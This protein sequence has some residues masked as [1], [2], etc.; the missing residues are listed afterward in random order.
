M[1]A[2]N[3]K[4]L[5]DTWRLRGQMLSIALV[6]AGGV[7]SV[8]TM[9]S[10]YR[11]LERSRDAYYRDQRFADVFASLNR[12]PES[13][14]G[15][16]AAVPGVAAVGTR[17][18]FDATLRV[19]GLERS[20]T[21]RLVSI[22]DVPE[23]TLNDIFIR[24]GRYVAPRRD[25]EVLVSERFAGINGIAVGDTIGALINGRHRTLHVVGLALSPEFVYET[26]P[27]G[28]F[29]GDERLF[30]VLWMG[31]HA[32]AAA[33]DMTGA[34][35]DVVVRLGPGGS[36]RAVIAA[37][38]D[39]LEPFGGRGAFG[40]DDQLSNRLLEDELAQIRST[41]TV[42]P[43][44]FLG[45]AAF[46]LH[47]VML[48]L[49]A[50]ERE[51]I[52]TLK[53]FGYDDSTVALHYL[54]YA[55]LA[56]GVGVVIGLLGGIRLG[57]GYTALYSQYFR[58]PALEHRVSWPLALGAILISTAAAV[59]GALS[60]VRGA[61]RLQPAEAMRAEPPARFKPLFLERLG[62]HRR[63]G[64]SHRMILRNLERRP[65]RAFFAATG[66]A[67]A[68]A[69]LLIGF[70]MLDSV[71]AMM[72]LQFHVIQREDAAVS[73][74]VPVDRRALNELARVPG[75]LVVEPFRAVPVRLSN[76]HRDRRLALTGL[77]S[78]GTLRAMVG[79]SGGVHPLPEHGL[80]LSSRLASVLDVRAGDTV[81]AELLDRG[82]EERTLVVSATVDELLGLNGYLALPELNRTLREG[83][84]VS[85]AYLRIA[86]GEEPAVFERL[87][88]MPRIASAI[89]KTAMVRSFD[90][91]IA[92]SIGITTTILL[93]L[94]S[95]L[96]IG[97]IYNGAR[98]A[99]S[100]RGRELA[101]LR[102]LGFTRAEVAMMLLGEQAVIT[103][104]ALPIGTLIG[105]G[106]TTLI[107][108]AFESD[109]YRLPVAFSLGTVLYSAAVIVG[110]AAVAGLLVRRRLDRAN[111]IEV[112]KT[113]E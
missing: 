39:V 70:I 90:E 7:L 38:D 97:V 5:R 42:I 10:T 84:H 33:S 2:L 37:I 23:P 66:V 106:V 25:D 57:E 14:A 24:S 64:A 62:L 96:A 28:G 91:Q 88:A 102:V 26:N 16:I 55:L 27:T 98:I 49:V 94:S 44:V 80:V 79:T 21:G 19:P 17:V 43:V 8:I 29:I 41:A 22:P 15:R 18:V 60:A 81:R 73:F 20:A 11:S 95:V 74:N 58:F 103:L 40:R 72:R 86:R 63:L 31:R 54:S 69:V 111:L 61:A 71:Q 75:V 45:I 92:E 78:E 82:S 87:G 109:L 34:F 108:Q 46:L 6:V 113:R 99:L 67:F 85:G 105:Y 53:A 52:A 50:T 112:L 104:L 107:M 56:V 89:S 93:M 47:I 51:Q 83:P 110:I 36:E 3:I 48:R 12:A 1:R 77:S 4:L 65:A 59:G 32:L 76:G 9:Q 100:E 35:N 68:L 30:G 101:S 13:V